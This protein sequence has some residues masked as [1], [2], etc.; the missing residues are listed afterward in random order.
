M[1]SCT[2]SFFGS[3]ISGC[4]IFVGSRIQISHDFR[5]RD[6]NFGIKMSSRALPKTNIPRDDPAFSL[7]AFPMF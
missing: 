7:K 3:G 2:E 1:G 6:K 4:A 5:I